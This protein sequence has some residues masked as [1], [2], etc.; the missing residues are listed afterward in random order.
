MR[1]VASSSLASFYPQTLAWT[2]R[3]PLVP[4]TALLLPHPRPCSC[5]PATAGLLLALTFLSPLPSCSPTAKPKLSGLGSG[6]V[7]RLFNAGFA[8]CAPEVLL[9]RVPIGAT[10]ELLDLPLLPLVPWCGGELPGDVVEVRLL[11]WAVLSNSAKLPGVLEE[12]ELVLFALEGDL[13]CAGWP[14]AWSEA[15]FWLGLEKASGEWPRP[16]TD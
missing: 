8:A 11:C 1:F 2:P 16:T 15:S 6:V 3:P 9:G 13:A 7:E 14:S 12:G 5:C 10:D 4:H